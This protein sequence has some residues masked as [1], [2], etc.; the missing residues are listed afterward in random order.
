MAEEVVPVRVS[1]ASF[2]PIAEDFYPYFALMVMNM[3]EDSLTCLLLPPVPP[4][5]LFTDCFFELPEPPTLS[6]MLRDI[7]FLL[8]V[9]LFWQL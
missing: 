2:A 8:P 3:D 7:L 6:T 9:A 1:L 4:T 5:L